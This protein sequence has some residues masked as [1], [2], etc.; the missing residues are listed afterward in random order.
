[1]T[2][3]KS[4]F[5]A[6]AFI[7]LLSATGGASAQ[8]NKMVT[9]LG[10]EWRY[11]TFDNGQGLAGYSLTHANVAQT[12]STQTCQ[13][14]AVELSQRLIKNEGAIADGQPLILAASWTQN[15][16]FPFGVDG[17][18]SVSTPAGSRTCFAR[19][20]VLNPVEYPK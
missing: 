9:W 1:M 18:I 16:T 15:Y 8:E 14:A 13:A 2:A 7:I 11:E 3:A 12:L 20:T 19:I 5:P 4:L 10:L 17:E 6:L